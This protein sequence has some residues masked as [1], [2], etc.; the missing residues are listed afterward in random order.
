MSKSLKPAAVI[1]FSSLAACTTDSGYVMNGENLTKSYFYDY[2]YVNDARRSGDKA[3]TAL[4]K[5]DEASA[6]QLFSDSTETLSTSVSA[7]R[8]LAAQRAETQSAIG[9]LA[10]G[11]LAFAGADKIDTST[12]AGQAQLENFLDAA[13]KIAEFGDELISEGANVTAEEAS[14]VERGIWRSPVVSGHK[15]PESIVGIS[16]RSKGGFCT[17]FFVSPT[18]VATSAHCFD[19]TDVVVIVKQQPQ[20]GEAF[21]TG[22]NV[23]VLVNRIIYPPQFDINGEPCNPNDF[24]FLEVAGQ[25]DSWLKI[26]DRAPRSGEKLFQLGYSGDLNNGFFMRID[27]GCSANGA[28]RGN[29]FRHDCASYGGNSGGPVLRMPTANNQAAEVVGV[30]SCG[31]RGVNRVSGSKGAAG[32]KRAKDFYEKSTGQAL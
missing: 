32:A 24:A 2:D 16:N 25:S 10:L 1:V 13:T 7:H 3:F 15:V 21:M 17:G 11:A 20:D 8:D 18:V 23:E 6:K 27:V 29:F 14:Y 22:R 5:G 26:S 28:G 9:G 31:V 12:A 19:P 4:L 30:H